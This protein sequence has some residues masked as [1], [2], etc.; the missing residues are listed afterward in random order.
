MEED[1][2]PQEPL[3]A[4]V[5]TEAPLGD[6]VHPLVLG[7][8]LGL[9]MWRW[10]DHLLDVLVGLGVELVELLGDV[11]AHVAVALLDRLGRLQALEIS[12]LREGKIF[13]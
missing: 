6:V 10:G 8:G 7:R 9:D 12:G 11:G 1:L 13:T 4:H 5:Y 3:V 2:W